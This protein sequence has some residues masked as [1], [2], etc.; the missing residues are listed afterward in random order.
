LKEYLKIGWFTD[1]FKY[2]YCCL[3]GVHE[4]YEALE[5][6]QLPKNWEMPYSISDEDMLTFL[7]R[8]PNDSVS[9]FAAGIDNSIIKYEYEK[10]V[11]VEIARVLDPKGCFVSCPHSISAVPEEFKGRQIRKVDIGVGEDDKY[12]ILREW[13]SHKGKIYFKI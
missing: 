8:L 4:D 3:R 13:R 2:N 12:D 9:L 5:K 1:D 11:G 10:E 7:R 6:R